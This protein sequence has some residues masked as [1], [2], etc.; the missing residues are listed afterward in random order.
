MS[1]FASHFFMNSVTVFLWSASVVLMNLSGRM[2]NACH[3]FLN[4]FDTS[5]TNSFGALPAFFAASSTFFP[6]S[7]VPVTKN[8]SFP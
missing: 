3:A 8:T 4:F 1:P 6:Y 5:S 7:S 2:F